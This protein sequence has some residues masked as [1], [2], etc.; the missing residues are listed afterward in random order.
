M[1]QTQAA[2]TFGVS[3]WSVVQ[4]A[5]A[6]RQG[7]EA[8]LAAK[9]RRRRAGEAGKLSTKQSARIRVLVV[10]KMPEQLKPLQPNCSTATSNVLSAKCARTPGKR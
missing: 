8:A 10:D 4:W 1:S 3:R 5:E 7:G 2:Q 9:R 6:E